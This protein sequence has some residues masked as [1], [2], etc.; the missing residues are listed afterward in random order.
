MRQSRQPTEYEF[1]LVLSGVD[2]LTRHVEDRLFEAGCDDATLS[3]RYGRVILTFTRTADSLGEAV[4]S[5]IE[6]VHRSGCGAQ[7][8]RVDVCDLVTESEIAKRIG[9]TRALVH[10]YIHGRRGPGGFPGPV[11]YVTSRSP[12]WYW[13]EVAAWLRQ[14]DMIGED[15]LIDAREMATINSS[16]EYSHRRRLNP[17]IADKILALTAD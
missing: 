13:S 10:Q 5:A 11:G 16:L 7:V 3:R 17:A 12:M 15:I 4:L 1:A 9:R 8:E 14:N 2:G 6:S